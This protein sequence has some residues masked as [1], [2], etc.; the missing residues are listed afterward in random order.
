MSRDE[1]RK[2]RGAGCGGLGVGES[3][4]ED[5]CYRGCIHLIVMGTSYREMNA[6]VGAGLMPLGRCAL[7]NAIM[8]PARRSHS[9][10]SHWTG[11]R[12]RPFEGCI[13]N[14]EIHEGR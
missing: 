6:L 4:W 10:V 5:R 8:S 13:L 14:D 12:A 3:H 7:F 2:A 1:R 9:S 11:R